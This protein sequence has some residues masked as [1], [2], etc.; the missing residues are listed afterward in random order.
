[1]E[2]LA[3][4]RRGQKA[5]FVR[6]QGTL[7]V[8]DDNVRGF[9]ETCRAWEARL[10]EYVWSAREKKRSRDDEGD[11]IRSSSNESVG[12]AAEKIT[13]TPG[14]ESGRGTS[15][16]LFWEGEEQDGILAELGTQPVAQRPMLYYGAAYQGLSTGLNVLICSLMPMKLLQEC[17]KDGQW[18]RMAMCVLLPFIFFVV[19][20]VADSIIGALAQ[21]FMPIKQMDE[22]TLYYSG[23]A[24]VR[25]RG[26]LPHITIVMPVYKESLKGV[27]APT[28]ESLQIAI[29]TYE[30]QGGTANI[31]VCE[32]G[33]QLVDEAERNSRVE[34]YAQNDCGWVARH[35]DNRAGRF[36]KSSN[37]NLTKAMS[38]RVEEMMDAERPTDEAALENWTQHDEDK[39]YYDC[40]QR[41][42]EEHEGRTWGSGNIR[43]GEYILLVDSDTRIPIDS[44]LDAV[45]EMEQSPEVA[46]LQHSSGTFLS[47][48][49]FFENGIAYF[50][51]VVNNS[52]SWTVSCGGSS[53]FMGHNAYLR[54]SALQDQMRFNRD[55]IIWSD[56]HVSEDFVMSLNLINAGYILRWATYAKQGYLEGVSLS[57]DDELNR[58]QKYSWGCS[59]MVFNPIKHWFTRSPFATLYRSFLWSDAASLPSKFATSSYVASYWAIASGRKIACIV[60][61]FSPTAQLLISSLDILQLL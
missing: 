48:A 14:S 26:N 32:D 60:R 20:F 54:W 3:G 34:Y 11:I 6:Q 51:S 39:I 24:P 38:L 37:M 28:I 25:L 43:I 2:A 1:M 31:L 50:T 61:L 41:A 21:I 27:L 17:L 44:F 56:E 19:M 29:Q 40:F 52:I 30:L 36:K 47:G 5:A 49:G 22:N 42:I 13:S 9:E 33:L 10:V 59:E 4:A 35:P 12:N 8:W 57:C 18:L 23:K 7:V 46:I 16:G 53:P 45:S 55:G 58:W 15:T